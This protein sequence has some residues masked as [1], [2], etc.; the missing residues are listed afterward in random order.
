MN[1]V[2]ET[3]NSKVQKVM[4]IAKSPSKIDLMPLGMINHDSAPSARDNLML[5][6]AQQTADL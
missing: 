1:D 2:D 4:K 3:N 5:L 6:D